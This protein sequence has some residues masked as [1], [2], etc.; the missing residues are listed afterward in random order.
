MK[1][2]VL[3]SIIVLVAIFSAS[4]VVARQ[5]TAIGNVEKNMFKNLVKGYLHPSISGWGIGLNTEKDSYL[6][7]KFHAV[8]TKSLPRDQILQILKEAKA[9]NTTS[10]TEV[11]DRI[12]DA[13]DAYNKTLIKGQIQINKNS[14]ILTGIV[15][16]DTTFTGTIRAKPDY[17]TCVSANV[18]A[19]DCEEQ[20]TK[21]GDISL[22]RKSAEFEAGKDRVWAGTMNFNA[23]AYTFV[24]IV[25]PRVGD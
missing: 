13:L 5:L 7:A 6:L 2:T 22:T 21:I 3:L 19:E 15:R 23:T 11:R 18:S 14:Y 20:S 9:G 24:A 8:S 25:N 17:S 4:I 12:K 16:T 10:W 1:K